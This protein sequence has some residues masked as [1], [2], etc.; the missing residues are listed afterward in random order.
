MMPPKPPPR[1]SLKYKKDGGKGRFGKSTKLQENS[2][3]D[4]AEIMEEIAMCSTQQLANPTGCATSDDSDD[5]SSSTSHNKAK[6]RKAK[7]R[8]QGTGRWNQGAGVGGGGS[9]PRTSTAAILDPND[10]RVVSPLRAK[11]IKLASRKL[12]PAPV[13]CTTSEDGKD[14]PEPSR[15]RRRA[16]GMSFKDRRLASDG[17][18][19]SSTASSNASRETRTRKSFKGGRPTPHGP[20]DGDDSARQHRA[21]AVPASRGSSGKHS[22][23]HRGKASSQGDKHRV[24]ACVAEDKR[25]RRVNRSVK[26]MCPTTA[27]VER[28]PK[29][30]ALESLPTHQQ[31]QQATRHQQRRPHQEPSSKQSSGSAHTKRSTQ[32]E[33]P[34]TRLQV[35]KSSC[36]ADEFL[37]DREMQV[38]KRIEQTKRRRDTSSQS[39]SS[40]HQQSTSGLQPMLSNE[41]EAVSVASSRRPKKRQGTGK[42]NAGGARRESVVPLHGP[43][44]EEVTPQQRKRQGTG[45]WHGSKPTAAGTAASKMLVERR[46]GGQESQTDEN[47]VDRVLNATNAQL[48]RAEESVNTLTRGK[49]QGT[50]RWNAGGGRKETAATRSLSLKNTQPDAGTPA[51]GTEQDG[52]E[53]DGS[54]QDGSEG[55]CALNNSDVVL[56]ASV[57]LAEEAWRDL[58][59]YR[60]CTLDEIAHE[61]QLKVDEGDESLIPSWRQ[62]QLQYKT[63]DKMVGMTRQQRQRHMKL[64]RRLAAKQHQIEKLIAGYLPAN[65]C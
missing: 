18:T 38:R 27:A 6:A 1:P 2:S 47:D 51:P 43:A 12:P 28:R 17:S 41:S 13:A 32:R 64:Q 10:A 19:A 7:A 21:S 31:V 39:S 15:G 42:W 62:E 55:T 34:S 44:A 60:D 25:A 61:S 35:A 52:T 23:L 20:R 58:A 11:S 63:H 48:S 54:E 26:H 56:A 46:S 16:A 40:T 30:L 49:R 5:T 9:V 36:G 65:E 29:S 14:K 50:G 57:Q 59:E 4:V 8:R 37:H 24:G 3:E 33:R 22:G 45:R 53:Q